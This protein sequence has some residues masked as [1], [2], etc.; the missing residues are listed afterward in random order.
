M[1]SVRR[2][3]DIEELTGGSMAHR[4]Y[5]I[6]D[7]RRDW[8][9]P[10]ERERLD[11]LKREADNG[12]I[13]AKD[14]EE[15]FKFLPLTIRAST[16]LEM[17]IW[18]YNWAKRTPGLTREVRDELKRDWT[19]AW[20]WYMDQP[21]YSQFFLRPTKDDEGKYTTRSQDSSKQVAERDT[22]MKSVGEGFNTFLDS[23]SAVV[24]FY[25][26]G[27]E[28][29]PVRDPKGLQTLVHD[30]IQAM[31]DAESFQTEIRHELL[32]VAA[33]KAIDLLTGKAGEG[34]RLMKKKRRT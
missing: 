25:K 17:A 24:E 5:T 26:R 20:N 12:T 6:D 22:L 7:P 4:R 13:R 14:R 19:T 27:I 15:L 30:F 9:T 34:K 18:S 11:E 29:I 1:P 32:T 2:I 21:P 3:V 23:Q 31:Y 8:I 33:E 28:A 10:E 16:N